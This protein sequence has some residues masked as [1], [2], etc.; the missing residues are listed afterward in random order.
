MYP[1]SPLHL[2]TPKPKHFRYPKE[3]ITVGDEVRKARIDR[4]LTQHEVAEMIGVNRNAIYEMELNNRKLTIYALHKAYCFLG[5]IP[6]TLN[7]DE[8]TLAGKMFIH[9]IINGFSLKEVG[10]K[11]GLDK[12]TISRFEIGKK[13]KRESIKKIKIYL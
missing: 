12:S 13:V 4:G 9:R 11:V 5:Y 8:S 10:E 7:I 6:T 3:I 2:T 1:I